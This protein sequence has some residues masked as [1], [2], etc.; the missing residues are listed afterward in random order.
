MA[1][2][3][4]KFTRGVPPPE[5]FPTAELSE[6]AQ[7]VLA[8]EGDTILQYGSAGGYA[9]LRA[10]IAQQAGVAE[11][12]VLL[13]QGS[14]QLADFC[15]RLLIEPGMPVY[16]EE[17]TYDRALTIYRRAR[18]RVVRLP[19][20]SRW[21]RRRCGG[22]PPGERRPAGALLHDPRFP[23]SQ[24]FRP[25]A[26]KAAAA[27]RA[28]PTATVSGLSRMCPIAGCAI[29]GQ[30]CPAC[31]SWRRIA[32]VQMSSYSKLISPGLRV[33]YMILPDTLARAPHQD[34]RGYLH[35]FELSEPGDRLRIHP[36]WLVGAEYLP[37]MRTV[38]ATARRHAGGPG[39]HR[40]T[41]SP[42]GCGRP[43][44]FSPASRCRFSSPPMSCSPALARSIWS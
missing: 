16:V 38:S 4:L 25:L 3:S 1:P 39:P 13:G 23:E 20:A 32:S 27:G 7:S 15:A 40:W 19:A 44:A 43:A 9:P 6:C 11:N 21:A 22:S 36:S 10:L 30:P 17:P 5:S 42:P 31:S 34:G 18:A 2:S 41:A 8:K 24:R 26:R 29:E 33:G 37:P 14:L 28:G 35:Q 12:R